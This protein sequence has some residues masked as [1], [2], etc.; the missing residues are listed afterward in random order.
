M[1]AETDKKA[2]RREVLAAR[3]A[4]PAERIKEC[5][6]L[7]AE[8]VLS[9]K[10]YK[11]ADTLLFFVPTDIEVDVRPVIER[12]FADGKRVAV[13]RCFAGRPEMA[14]YLISGYDDLEPGAYGIL[15]PKA[16]CPEC[17]EHTN[18]LCMTPALCCGKDGSRMGFGR[19]YYDRF[20]AGFGGVKCAVVFGDFLFESV[21]TE[22]TDVPMDMIVSEKDIIYILQK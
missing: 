3:R 22:P 12:A 7:I 11:K 18:A 8:T 4:F 6:Q 19:G 9:L 15:E 16:H 1:T 21:P 14:F 10:E 13:P 5:S 17:T 2:F 20:L